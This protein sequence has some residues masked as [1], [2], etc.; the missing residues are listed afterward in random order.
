MSLRQIL[1]LGKYLLWWVR[2]I[3]SGFS[4]EG[5]KSDFI[6]FNE[7][8]NLEAKLRFLVLGSWEIRGCGEE[9]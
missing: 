8:L 1:I 7:L 9:T 4:W 3:D 6:L 5:P 2:T